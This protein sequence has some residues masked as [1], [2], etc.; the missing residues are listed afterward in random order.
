MHFPEKHVYLYIFAKAFDEEYFFSFLWAA[1]P[2]LSRHIG[3]GGCAN[4]RTQPVSDVQLTVTHL[5]CCDIRT[6]NTTPSYTDASIHTDGAWAVTD[7]LL[8]IMTRYSCSK[9]F[10]Q[11]V[12]LHL[13]ESKILGILLLKES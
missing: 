13:L 6:L 8:P 10:L 2:R 9:L 11:Y 5:L 7:S 3:V 1:F 12:D 4:I